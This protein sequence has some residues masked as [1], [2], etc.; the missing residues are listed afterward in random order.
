MGSCFS[1]EP[2]LEH[3]GYAGQYLSKLTS[4]LDGQLPEDKKA[5]LQ[6]ELDRFIHM[7]HAQQERY[8]ASKLGRG[9][10]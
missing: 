8:A 9:S 10:P 4:Q 7:N 6:D 3:E 2:E 1:R 5:E